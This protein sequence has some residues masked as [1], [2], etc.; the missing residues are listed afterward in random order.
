MEVGC[1]G[2]EGW[3]KFIAVV[4]DATGRSWRVS[5]NGAQP[6]RTHPRGTN[7]FASVKHLYRLWQASNL[8]AG[9]LAGSSETVAEK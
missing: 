9:R 2:E 6:S 8:V 7:R 4:K 1:C 3:K 5:E